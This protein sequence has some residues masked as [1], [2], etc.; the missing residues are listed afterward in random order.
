[1]I[2]LDEVPNLV[3]THRFVYS[4]HDFSVLSLEKTVGVLKKK[5]EL[6]FRSQRRSKI[7]QYLYLHPNQLSMKIRQ[8]LAGKCR[9]KKMRLSDIVVCWPRC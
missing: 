4:M 2:L 8:L 5:L 6:L 9:M 3:I 1:M 7:I